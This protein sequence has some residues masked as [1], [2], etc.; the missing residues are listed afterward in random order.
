VAWHVIFPNK[1]VYLKLHR[2]ESHVH[3]FI[4]K[5]GFFDLVSEESFEA[6]HP[7]IAKVMQQ[8]ESDVSVRARIKTSFRRFVRIGLNEQVQSV[9]TD[10]KQKIEDKK[11]SV[12]HRT[13]VASCAPEE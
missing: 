3:A 11:A 7:K 2:L 1:D 12:Y 6:F 10:V 13:S 9:V 5:N 8:L 4:K